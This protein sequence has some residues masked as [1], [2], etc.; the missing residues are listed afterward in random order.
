MKVR[1]LEFVSLGSTFCRAEYRSLPQRRQL[2]EPLYPS[3]YVM[4]S[5]GDTQWDVVLTG[6]GL[7]VSLLALYVALALRTVVVI[8]D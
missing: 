5:L 8:S 3:C 1:T 2:L 6:T 4:E 7:S